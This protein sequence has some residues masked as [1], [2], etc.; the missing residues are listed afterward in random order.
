MSRGVIPFGSART[1]AV[2]FLA[3]V[4]LLSCTIGVNAHKKPTTQER[5]QRAMPAENEPQDIIK[6][7]TDLVPVNV[8][9][10][11]AKGRL[12]RDL[13]KE[14]FKLFEDGVE[15]PI[16]SFN[17]ETISGSPRPVAIVFAIDISGSMTREEVDR[18]SEAMREFSR[19][20]ANHPAV[21][22]LMTFG[23][24][25]KTVQSLTSD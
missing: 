23:M 4:F 11:D 10:T 9:V 18:V 12:I 14:N 24:R 1:H 25:V 15:R 3:I 8:T 17:V 5:T 13:K 2:V 7:D 19:R 6:I 22:G 21:F 16:S 20:L